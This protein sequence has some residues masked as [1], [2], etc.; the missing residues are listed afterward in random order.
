MIQI[1]RLAKTYIGIF[2]IIFENVSYKNIIHLWKSPEM[3]GND[4]FDFV[5]SMKYFDGINYFGGND[6]GV[7]ENYN[8]SPQFLAAIHKG[9]HIGCVSIFD[10]SADKVRVSD[11]GKSVR[12][13]GLYVAPEYRGRGIS[14]ELLQLAIRQAKKREADFFWALAGPNSTHVHQKVGFRTVTEQMHDF[15]D[16]NKSK[17]ANSYLRYDIE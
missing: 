15:P 3:W 16:G 8:S 10:V 9:F 4:N 2:M 7:Y 17:H 14:E 13:R 6:L 11:T 12:F 1:S 5:S